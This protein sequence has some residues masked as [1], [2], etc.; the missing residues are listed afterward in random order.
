LTERDNDTFDL[1]RVLGALAMIWFL[2]LATVELIRHCSDFQLLEV[3]GGLAAMFA[4]FGAAIGYKARTE[5][6]PKD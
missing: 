6:Q 2:M 1:L 5:G 3:S 4:S